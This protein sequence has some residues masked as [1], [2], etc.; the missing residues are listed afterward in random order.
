MLF[1]QEEKAQWGMWLVLSLDGQV[2]L[3]VSMREVE[4]PGRVQILEES[5]AFTFA[6]MPLE[7]TGIHQL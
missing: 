2:V 4:S 7:K 6:L 3:Q 1:K 5:V